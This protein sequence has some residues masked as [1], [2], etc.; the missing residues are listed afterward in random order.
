[1]KVD[2]TPLTVLLLL[3]AV[4]S[5]QLLH[6]YPKLPETIVVHFGSSGQ[7]NGWSGKAGFF[8][9]YGAIEAAIVLAGILL[10]LFA[11]RMPA[12]FLNMP[13]RDYW[14]SPERREESLAFFWTQTIWIEAM[15][16]AFLIAVA[17]FVFRANLAAG[18]PTLT[19]DFVVVLVVFVAAVLWQSFR[20]VRRFLRSAA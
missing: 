8:T 16:L 15:A 5:G 18:A 14:L 3:A 10:A 9:I 2:K 17:E 12:T 11:E 4:A 20:I 13:N 19:R 1:M 7:A 6:Y